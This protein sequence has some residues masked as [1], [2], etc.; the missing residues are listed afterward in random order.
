MPG[1]KGGE[2][3]QDVRGRMDCQEE[4]LA[5]IYAGTC[6]LSSQRVRN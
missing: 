3:N 2:A 4:M 5:A 6:S 1:S